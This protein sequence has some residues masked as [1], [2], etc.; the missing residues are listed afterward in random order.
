VLSLEPG[1]RLACL[2]VL[3]T[4]L[5]GDDDARDAAGRTA[6]VQRLV[7]LKDWA[8]PLD[9]P[10]DAVSVHVLEAVDVAGAILDYAALNRVDHIVMGARGASALRRH[11]G[12]VSAAVVAEAPCTVTVVRLKGVE[13]EGDQSSATV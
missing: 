4:K 1:A 5:V 3:R 7:A 2:T 8:R 10:E 11:L 6:Y 9:L 13:G 12:S